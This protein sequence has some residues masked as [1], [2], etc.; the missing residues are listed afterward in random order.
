MLGF[1]SG[2]PQI[3]ASPH[4]LDLAPYASGSY[5]AQWNARGPSMI[6]TCCVQVVSLEKRR[7]RNLSWG[8]SNHWIIEQI[9]EQV[10]IGHRNWGEFYR[11]FRYKI[12]FLVGVLVCA[13]HWMCGQQTLWMTRWWVMRRANIGWAMT[14]LGWWEVWPCR[15]GSHNMGSFLFL[16]HQSRMI[17]FASF[18]TRSDPFPGEDQIRKAWRCVPHHF[19]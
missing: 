15:N 1:T 16:I 10:S 8:Y 3:S 6:S 12:H 7:L 13:W 17:K 11:L 14:L 4:Q 19:S 9:W 18:Q 2:S 5:N